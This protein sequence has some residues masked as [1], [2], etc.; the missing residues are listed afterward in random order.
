MPWKTDMT[1]SLIPVCGN[2][3]TSSCTDI[4]RKTRKPSCS[5]WKRKFFVLLHFGAWNDDTHK[6]L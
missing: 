3:Y 1:K 6:T 4:T 5:G 2:T